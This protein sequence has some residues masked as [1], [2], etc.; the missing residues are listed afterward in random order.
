MLSVK[1]DTQQSHC[2]DIS[3]SGHHMYEHHEHHTYKR[4]SSV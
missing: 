2:V 4:A 1:E 3:T